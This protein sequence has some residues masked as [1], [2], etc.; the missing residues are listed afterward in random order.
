MPLQQF[1]YGSFHWSTYHYQNAGVARLIES[2]TGKVV[3]SQQCQVSR[4]FGDDE[5]SLALDKEQF[6][7]N[8]GQRVNEILGYAAH[9]CAGKMP[10]II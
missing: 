7:A 4:L 10:P 5:V 2:A 9:Q 1:T 6:T 8:E 3:W